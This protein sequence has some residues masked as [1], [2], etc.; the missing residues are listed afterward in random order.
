MRNTMV[1]SALF[2]LSLCA[3]GQDASTYLNELAGDYVSIKQN[4]WEYA[5]AASEG[6]DV[7]KMEKERGQLIDASEEA[8]RKANEAGDYD[9][10]TDYR[11]ALLMYYETVQT[12]LKEDYANIIA[13]E[14]NAN[15]SY[16]SMESYILAKDAVL[17][18]QI[19]ALDLVN[20][21]Y[22]VF[23]AENQ[24]E[25]GAT[26]VE[27]EGEML[28]AVQ[29][30]DYFNAVFLLYC[31]SN[32]LS[33]SFREAIENG[34]ITAIEQGSDALAL[35]ANE[36]MD[37]LGGME[38]FEGG[39]TLIEAA[40][41]IFKMHT[42][43]AATAPVLIEYLNRKTRF[44]NIKEAL[45]Q[46]KDSEKTEEDQVDFDIAQRKFEKAKEAYIALEEAH[47]KVRKQRV[48][49]WNASVEAFKK[50][51]FVSEK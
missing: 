20:R 36:G 34:D 16:A 31:E 37:L 12:I 29:V 43:E 11:D 40:R 28:K 6:E 22:E 19:A 21:A 13:L 2:V 26:A 25:A 47:K 24:M 32:E 7:Q 4:M 30:H 33:D 14:K 8:L 18:K 38:P 46:K 23:A 41:A 44:E 50:Q 10:D 45:D 5:Q 39:G 27:L 17:E 49:V 15:Q 3:M 9:G 42:E 51:Y 48:D 35:N 1:T